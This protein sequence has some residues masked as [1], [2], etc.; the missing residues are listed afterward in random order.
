[1]IPLS[2]IRQAAEWEDS[3]CLDCGNVQT[4][5]SDDPECVKCGG[6]LVEGTR[7]LSIWESIMEEE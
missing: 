2:H 5:T 3:V 4:P 1:M 7:L 6:E